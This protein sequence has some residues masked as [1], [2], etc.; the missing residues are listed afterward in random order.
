MAALTASLHVTSVLLDVTFVAIVTFAEPHQKQV[1][2]VD[3]PP[4]STATQFHAQL[5]MHRNRTLIHTLP[6]K[7]YESSVQPLQEVQTRSALAKH[8]DL[9]ACI[10]L[11]AALMHR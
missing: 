4:A 5:L 2:I 7:S 1:S 8:V 11:A 6:A 10:E 3:T 9:K